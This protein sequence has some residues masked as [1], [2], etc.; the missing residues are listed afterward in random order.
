MELPIE[1]QWPNRCA[2]RQKN[3]N[4]QERQVREFADSSR[5]WRRRFSEMWGTFL[6][7]I[8]AAGTIMVGAQSGNVSP[9]A[10]AVGPGL[11]VMVVIYFMGRS[12]ALTSIQL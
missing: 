11:I 5:E 12:A 7:V 4:L 1:G 9:T 3:L 10:A 6:L 8:V 2:A